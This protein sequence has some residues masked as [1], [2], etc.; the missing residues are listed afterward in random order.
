MRSHEAGESILRL[1]VCKT[2][3]AR[4]EDCQIAQCCDHNYF[5][6][7]RII[8]ILIPEVFYCPLPLHHKTHV[9]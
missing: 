8:T 5:Y 4:L 2:V 9:F 1:F 3:C 7:S 6:I